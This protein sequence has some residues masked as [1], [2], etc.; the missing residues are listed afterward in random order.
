MAV[1]P[2]HFKFYCS[3]ANKFDQAVLGNVAP[4]LPVF[5]AVDG[6][7]PNS[8]FAQRPIDDHGVTVQDVQD[9]GF[10]QASNQRLHLG[11]TEGIPLNPV[12]EEKPILSRFQ[13]WR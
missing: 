7:K 1:E 13:L 4:F 8:H 2:M 6:I 5:W 3:T 12:L 9:L 11:V 10:W